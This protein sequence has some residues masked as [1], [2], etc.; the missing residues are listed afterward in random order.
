MASRLPAR[1]AAPQ[2]VW[3]V[4]WDL[5]SIRLLLRLALAS[6]RG[7]PHPD[8]HR[9]LA[10]RYARLA[11]HHQRAGRTDRAHRLR[12]RSVH[13]R[14]LAGDD[15]PPYAAAMAMPRPSRGAHVDAVSRHRMNGPDDAA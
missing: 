2:S 8:V 11:H 3:S 4:R 14:S 12:A 15:G 5:W 13:H 9:Y 6:G 1:P 7:E 10:D